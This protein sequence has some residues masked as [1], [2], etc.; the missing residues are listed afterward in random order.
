EE[1]R[2]F[3]PLPRGSAAGRV[4][5]V[6]SVLGRTTLQ[7]EPASTHYAVKDPAYNVA[8]T[9]VNAWTAE[10]AYEISDNAIKDNA[11]HAGNVRTDMNPG[12]ELDVAEGARTS[13]QLALVG[14]DGPNGGFFHQGE[15]L[16]W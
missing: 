12:A 2:A 7:A 11:N 14:P 8:K 4:V 15:T 6:S 3:L 9:A 10:L 13:V 1:T 5:N 16:P